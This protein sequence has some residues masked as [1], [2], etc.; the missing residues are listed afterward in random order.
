[1]RLH[2]ILCERLRAMYDRAQVLLEEENQN[3]QNRRES[4]AI[5]LR[6]K[7]KNEIPVEDYYPTFLDMLKNVLDGNLEA[8][9][10]E[11]SL[12]EMFGIHAYVAFTLDRVS[13]YGHFF[14]V[15]F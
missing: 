9:T 3:K 8:T 13:N 14:F 4:T 1:M 15:N 5:A 6:L 12:R 7:P 2:A 11:D 10:Y